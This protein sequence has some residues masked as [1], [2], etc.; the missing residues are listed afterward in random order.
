MILYPLWLRKAGAMEARLAT[1]YDVDDADDDTT[2]FRVFIWTLKTSLG[3]LRAGISLSLNSAAA[4][5]PEHISL[6]IRLFF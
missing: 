1:D 2:H 6:E 3:L 5:T 4:Q